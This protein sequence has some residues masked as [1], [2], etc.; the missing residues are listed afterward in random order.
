MFA[1]C[2]V[3]VVCSVW[4][5]VHVVRCLLVVVCWSLSLCCVLSVVR[6]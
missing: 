5:S 1:V 3:C 4:C 2:G 6:F